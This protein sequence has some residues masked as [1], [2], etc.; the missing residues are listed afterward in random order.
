[1]ELLKDAIPSMTHVAFLADPMSTFST[2]YV[3][4]TEAAAQALGVGLQGV[5]AGTPEAIE[6]ALA[7]IATSG[8]NALMIQDSPL[9][10]AQRQRIS[11]F[12]RTH[13]LPTVCGGRQYVKAGCLMA[14][15]P[16]HVEMFRRAAVFVDKLL[17][18]AK[19]AD[20]PMELPHKLKLFLTLQ[21]AEVLGITLP[22]TLLSLADGVMK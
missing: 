3:R 19:P 12:A 14:C 2:P 6:A 17:K 18:G 21:I 1:L 5:D 8:A 20:L 13:R 7:T 15:S 22:P 11:D 16:S 4:V 10:S 9:F